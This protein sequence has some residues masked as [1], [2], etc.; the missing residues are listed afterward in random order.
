MPRCKKSYRCAGGT[1]QVRHA[2]EALVT[3]MAQLGLSCGAFRR[4]GAARPWHGS[5]RHP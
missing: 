3:A 1:E 2:P 4:R 5:R